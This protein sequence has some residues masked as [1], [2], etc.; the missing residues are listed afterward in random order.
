MGGLYHERGVGRRWE[1]EKC[2]VEIVKQRIANFFS[3]QGGFW[4]L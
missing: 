2:E 1:R 4:G 3:R